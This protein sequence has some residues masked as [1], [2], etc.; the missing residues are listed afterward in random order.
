[1]SSST[2]FGGGISNREWRRIQREMEEARKRAEYEAMLRKFDRDMSDLKQKAKALDEIINSATS[3]GSAMVRQQQIEKLRQDSAQYTGGGISTDL[4][5]YEGEYIPTDEELAL[6]KKSVYD[7]ALESYAQMCALMGREMDTCFQYDDARRDVLVKQLTDETE[8]LEKIYLEQKKNIYIYETAVKVLKDMGYELVGDYSFT[9]RSGAEIKSTLLKM[10][11][12]TGV[13]LVR[14]PDGQY[15]FELVGVAEDDHAIT[16]A[17]IEELFKK[18][19][20]TCIPRNTIFR[21]KMEENGVIMNNINIRPADRDMCR[22]KDIR[23]YTQTEQEDAAFAVMEMEQQQN[24][25]V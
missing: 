3:E 15:T 23:K 11:D 7:K 18:M 24:G 17:E 5:E 16:E 8:R 10:D 20:A 6:Q 21:K 14:T 25:Q 13:N 9:Q 22:L 2:T 12:N 19:D 1:M 4:A